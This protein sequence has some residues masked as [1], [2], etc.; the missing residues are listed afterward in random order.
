MAI[1]RGSTPILTVTVIGEDLTQ[2]EVYLTIRQGET[3]LTK[4]TPS[5][6]ASIWMVKDGDNTV[7]SA[8]LSQEE[9]LAFN[10][11]SSVVQIRW[12]EEDGTAHVS[13]IG[14]I[15]L[16]DVLLKGVIEYGND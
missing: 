14:T 12:V 8:V 5:E 10:N 2:S 15:I 3:L 13:D 4:K 6:D 16:T 9:T 7:I 11:G 1:R